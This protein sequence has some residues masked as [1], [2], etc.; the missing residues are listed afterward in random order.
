[1]S[2]ETD[3][4]LSQITQEIEPQEVAKARKASENVSAAYGSDGRGL[5]VHVVVSTPAKPDELF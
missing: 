2:Q 5:I 4:L 1:M 3:N